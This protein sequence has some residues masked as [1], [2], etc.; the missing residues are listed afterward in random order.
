MKRKG[1]ICRE[2]TQPV[3]M[4]AVEKFDWALIIINLYR[5]LVQYIFISFYKVDS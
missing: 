5:Y 2:L 4:Q 3:V 1:D